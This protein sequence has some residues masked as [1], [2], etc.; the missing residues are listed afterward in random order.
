MCD[1]KAV[2]FRM[3][4]LPDYCVAITLPNIAGDDIFLAIWPVLTFFVTRNLH[5]QNGQWEILYRPMDIAGSCVWMCLYWHVCVHVCVCVCVCAFPTSVHY[6]YFGM[7]VLWAFSWTWYALFLFSLLSVK[8]NQ[9]LVIVQLL[10][11]I[12]E[13]MFVRVCMCVY[14]CLCVCTHMKVWN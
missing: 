2:Q 14:I 3:A 1:M 6:E 9:L 7:C 13:C 4:L 5:Q 8:D 10:V 12:Y 11:L